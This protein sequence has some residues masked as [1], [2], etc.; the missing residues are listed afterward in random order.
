MKEKILFFI[1]CIVI[2]I[3]VFTIMIYAK[4]NLLSFADSE[5]PNYLWNKDICTSTQDKYDVIILGDS[6]ANAAYM[7]EVLSDSCINLS[8]GGTTPMENYYTL[9]E[10]L[11]NN[12]APKVAYISFMDFHFEEADCYWKRSMYSHRYT[13]KDSL[14]ML[15]TALEYD[16]ESIIIENARL[17]WIAYQLYIHNKYITALCNASFNQR[18]N[19]NVE[20]YKLNDLHNGRYIARGWGEYSEA[21]DIEYDTFY[22]APLFDDYYKRLIKLCIDNNIKVHLVKL[23]L[24]ETSTFSDQYFEEYYSY[25]DD[26]KKSYPDIIIDWWESYEPKYFAD[27]HHMNDHGALKFSSEIKTK[28]SDEFNDLISAKQITAINNSVKNEK[29]LSEMMKW[30]SICSE[31]TLLI[32]DGIGN[33]ESRYREDFYQENLIVSQ[34]LLE[35]HRKS[36]YVIGVKESS[37]NF[38]AISPNESSINIHPGDGSIYKW[39]PYEFDGINILVIDNIHGKVVCEKSFVSTQ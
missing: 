17:N 8:L 22:V 39:Y 37:A 14:E 11:A 26:L 33:F 25:Y 29:Y 1:K 15:N 3:P 28:Y 2:M 16:D 12:K 30:A 10:Y 21:E 36:L 6:V 19:T 34:N 38:N 23:P 5:A 20:A 31:Y 7:P 35:N 32:Y 27:E 13:W 24:P 18:Y 9:K 4:T